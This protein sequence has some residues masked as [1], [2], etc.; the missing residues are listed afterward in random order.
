MK[1]PLSMKEQLDEAVKDGMTEDAFKAIRAELGHA[2]EKWG[3]A[4][5][6]KNTANDWIAYIVHYAGRAVTLPWNPVACRAMLVKVAGLCVSAIIQIDIN[7]GA[8]P[9]RHY[10]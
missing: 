7:H 1:R 6:D 4:F 2:R 9:K 8:L 3:D 5:D 10:D